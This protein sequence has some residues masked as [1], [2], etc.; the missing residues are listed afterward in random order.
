MRVVRIL[1]AV[2]VVSSLAGSVGAKPLEPLVIGW[3][4]FF[5]VSWD[6]QEGRDRQLVSGYVR[7]ESGH[8]A[9]RMQL[10]I[11]G[12]DGAGRVT[13]QQVDW[14]GSTVP[15]FGHAYFE[16]PARTRAPQHRVRVFAFD[17]LQARV[18]SP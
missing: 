14:L 8:T 11:E 16:V 10:L 6:T 9:I 13:T 15:P 5:T 12:L 7:N 18:E 4:R 3:E 17:V 2:V 1:V